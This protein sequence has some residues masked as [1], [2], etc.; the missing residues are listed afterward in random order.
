MK[1][2]RIYYCDRGLR[3]DCWNDE[4]EQF[5]S[6]EQAKQYALKIMGS[7][8][9]KIQPLHDDET[10]DHSELWYYGVNKQFE[11]A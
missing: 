9:F 11:E 4:V 1:K 3:R 8:D 6:M 5:E 2:F 10:E 7:H